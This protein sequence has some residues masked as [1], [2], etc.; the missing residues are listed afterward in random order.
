MKKQMTIGNL[1]AIFI[2]EKV[3][4]DLLDRWE[5]YVCV[6]FNDG[7]SYGKHPEFIL[8]D[9][10]VAKISKNEPVIAGR[11]V[12]NTV[13]KVEQILKNGDLVP[14]NETHESAPSSFFIYLL[15]NHILIFLPE[16]PG[17]PNVRSFKNF[18]EKTVNKERLRYIREM[19]QKESL[20]EQLLVVE[21]NPPIYVSY[22]PI[23]TI[24]SLD[25]EFEKIIKVKKIWVRH[26]YQNANLDIKSW[27]SGD[28]SILRAIKA[29][30]IDH[31]ITQVE[32]IQ[33]TK[34]FVTDL[35]KANNASFRVDGVSETG[36]VTISNEGS[37]YTS[38]ETPDYESSED[39][40]AVAEKLYGT[41]AKDVSAGNIPKV[42][43]K[44]DASKIA[45]IF[46]FNAK[47]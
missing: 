37:K 9:V 27:I 18:V 16:N 4:L 6:V 22:I 41:Y 5:E 40:L 21:D 20:E 15:K 43:D 7:Y 36:T 28:D 42:P 26:F 34:D 45:K 47:K 44:N 23:P 2:G 31:T 25:S 39:V 13:L 46:K 8:K 33:A 24:P 32:N 14:K 30:K 38:Y 10:R 1:N 3:K 19:K 12:K 11:F 29:P 35:A 17:A